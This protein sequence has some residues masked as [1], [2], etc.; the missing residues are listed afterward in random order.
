MELIYLGKEEVLHMP[1]GTYTVDK[2]P[3]K[4]TYMDCNRSNITISETFESPSEEVMNELY[5]EAEKFFLKKYKIGEA[6]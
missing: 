4:S 1:R 5:N 2:V 3:P 6:K